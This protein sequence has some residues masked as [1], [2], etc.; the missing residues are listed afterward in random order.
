MQLFT[1]NIM[2]IYI[3]RRICLPDIFFINF[4]VIVLACLQFVSERC[5]TLVLY[6]SSHTDIAYLGSMLGL[7]RLC[8]NPPQCSWTAPCWHIKWEP[9]AYI[10]QAASL[11]NF[12]TQLKCQ[13]S[14]QRKHSL[15][16]KTEHIFRLY[17]NWK[18][19]ILLISC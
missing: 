5:T 15:K 2:W 7:W 3:S 19:I 12:S 17:T 4:I 16:N 18:C 1:W 14:I 6:S 11:E 13:F 10:Q 8:M 9:R